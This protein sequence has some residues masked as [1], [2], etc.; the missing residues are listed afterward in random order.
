MR[1][2]QLGALIAI[3]VLYCF[4]VVA[5]AAAYAG[6]SHASHFVSELG[7]PD[8]PHP[9]L[10]NNSIIAMGTAALFGCVGLAGALRDLSDTR[11]WPALAAAALG[12]WGIAMVMGG[13][14]PLPDPRHDGFGLALAAPFVPLFAFL[15]L[16]RVADSGGMRLFLAA[17]VIGSVIPL[18][19]MTGVGGVVTGENVGLW[20][21]INSAFAIPWLAVL[22]AWLLRRSR[23]MPVAAGVAEAGPEGVLLSAARIGP[24]AAP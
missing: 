1:R 23:R 22:A 15:A 12:L 18:S 21:R 16:R 11:L 8:A 9:A 3:P 2:L 14:F 19:L 7:A 13:A 6:Y 5:G 4:A 17:V 24:G 10:F 20:Q